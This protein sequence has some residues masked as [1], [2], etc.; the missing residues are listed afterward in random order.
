[1]A[2]HLAIVL[3]ILLTL[4]LIFIHVFLF[5]C[6]RKLLLQ[7]STRRTHLLLRLA[8]GVPLLADQLGSLF[9]V[10]VFKVARVESLDVENRIG[11]DWTRDLTLVLDGLPF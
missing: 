10:N 1:M 2:V 3:D 7:D 4:A 11:S 5:D 6:V 8:Q 9:E